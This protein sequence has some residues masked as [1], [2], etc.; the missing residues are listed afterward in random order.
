MEVH[1]R[2][3]APALIAS[4][5]DQSR[6][7]LDAKRQPAETDDDQPRWGHLRIAEEDRKEARLEQEGLPAEAIE[8]P[9]DVDDRLVEAPQAEPREHRHWERHHLR[10]ADEQQ[11][12]NDDAAPRGDRQPPIRVAPVEDARRVEEAGPREDPRRRLKPSIAAQGGKLAGGH[13]E[14]D[15]VDEGQAALD[16]EPGD[17]VVGGGEIRHRH[18]SSAPW[19]ARRDHTL[20]VWPIAGAPSTTVGGRAGVVAV[21]APTK[22]R[23]RHTWPD[24]HRVIL[25]GGAAASGGPERSSDGAYRPAPRSTPAPQRGLR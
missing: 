18:Q 11:Q 1:A 23:Y 6:P 10:Q 21:A 15:D 5:L 7:E 14:R 22:P 25:S 3:I 12:G 20:G 16:D 9:A 19:R 17:R 13:D 8:R 2:E 4:Q 24:E